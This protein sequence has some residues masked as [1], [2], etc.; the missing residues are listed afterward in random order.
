MAQAATT[1]IEVHNAADTSGDAPESLAVIGSPA[2]GSELPTADTSEH[3]AEPTATQENAAKSNALAQMPQPALE[4][5]AS[6]VKKI[7]NET[8]TTA[9]SALTVVR[10]IKRT[11]EHHP[12]IARL[13]TLRSQTLRQTSLERRD[14]PSGGGWFGRGDQPIVMTLRT[15]EFSDG[16]RV[17]QL[18]PR[19]DEP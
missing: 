7:T 3:Q 15:I 1:E 17:Q 13:R 18:L 4:S 6:D 10:R 19:T 11:R 2:T 5:G 12:Q 16:R 14:V 9:S 8:A